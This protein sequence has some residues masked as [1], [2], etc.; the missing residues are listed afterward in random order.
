MLAASGRARPASEV[1]LHSGPC[2]TGVDRGFW[3]GCHGGGTHYPVAS[4]PPAQS[5]VHPTFCLGPHVSALSGQCCAGKCNNQLSGG[6]GTALR[7]SVSQFLGCT[8]AQRGQFQAIN[9]RS[10]KTELG[11]YA[12][13]PRKDT[14]DGDNL[15]DTDN[16]SEGRSFQY[17]LPL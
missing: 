4:D 7:G 16:S 8:Y 12:R 14:T 1:M 10:P 13:F 5:Q 15:R 17:L 2:E 6:G 9:M 11:R 3:S